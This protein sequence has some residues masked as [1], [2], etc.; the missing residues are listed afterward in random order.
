MSEPSSKTPSRAV[1]IGGSLAG[2]LAAAAV[3]DYVDAIVIVEAHEL[4][5]GPEP[6]TGVPQAAHFHTLLS[7]GAEAIDELLPGSIARMVDAGA[8]RVPVTTDVVMYAPEG[9]YRRWQR[10]THYQVT[11]SRDLIDSVIRQRVLKHRKVR[12]HERTKVVDLLGDKHRVTGVRLRS[13][14]G[15]ETEIAAQLVIDASG[16]SSRTPHWLKDLGITRLPEARIDSGLIYASRIYKAPVPTRG[17]P[18]INLQADFRGGQ[19]RA[20]GIIPIEQDQWHVSLIGPP[21]A[22]PGHDAAAFERYARAL[23]HPIV[24]DLLA[25]ATPLTDVTVNRSTSNRRYY[26]ERLRTWPDGLIVVGDA[27][28]AF[29]PVYGQGMAVAARGILAIKRAL[30]AVGLVDGVARKA[31]RALADPVAAAWALSVGT[32]I[33]R[34]TT[35]GKRAN[36]VDRALQRYVSRLS[37]AATGSHLAATALT[38]VLMLHAPPVSLMAPK[39][40]LAAVRGSSRPQLFGPPLSPAERRVLNES[41]QALVES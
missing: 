12:V 22:E 26:Y 4:P 30:S 21:D 39:V 40:V 32:D 24:A 17:W 8:N 33:H 29:N 6:R 7:G 14:T 38:E 35:K 27:V 11:A 2:M 28:A 19:P 23:R 1:I 15:D 13:S 36:I 18:I 10:A 9:W 20:G 5:D 34:P 16:R 37:R 3:S 31:Q 41:S 25:H